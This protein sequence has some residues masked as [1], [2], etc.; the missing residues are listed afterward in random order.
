MMNLIRCAIAS[1]GMQSIN[2]FEVFISFTDTGKAQ[3]HNL[4]KQTLLRFRDNFDL[5]LVTEKTGRDL[6]EAAA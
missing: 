1:S 5:S 6:N 2:D 4:F 3:R